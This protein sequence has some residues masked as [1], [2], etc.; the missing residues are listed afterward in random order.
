[1]EEFDKSKIERG[2]NKFDQAE[3]T[4]YRDYLLSLSEEEAFKIS[5]IF[6]YDRGRIIKEQMGDKIR[7]SNSHLQNHQNNSSDKKS[8][9]SKKDWRKD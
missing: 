9:S 7:Q 5:T 8:F 2:S 6:W 3:Y 4:R 1:M